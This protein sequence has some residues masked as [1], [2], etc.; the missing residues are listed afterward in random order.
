MCIFY[1]DLFINLLNLKTMGTKSKTELNSSKKRLFKAK[2]KTKI[3]KKDKKQANL[4]LIIIFGGAAI[5]GLLLI[6]FS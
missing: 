1:L 3:T 6:I 2:N 5:L 4:V